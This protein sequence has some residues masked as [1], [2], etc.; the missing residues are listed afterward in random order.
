MKFDLFKYIQPTFYLIQM[1]TSVYA[2][3]TSFKTRDIDDFTQHIPGNLLIEL[4]ALPT[5][6]ALAITEMRSELS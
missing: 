6:I 1:E 4:F 5:V 3:L 2:D